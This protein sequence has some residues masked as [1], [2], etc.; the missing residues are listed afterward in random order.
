MSDLKYREKIES[1]LFY[2]GISK[3]AYERVK[4]PV[5]ESN[6]RAFKHWSALA[7]FFWCYCLLMSLRAEDYT[8]CRPAYIVSLAVCIVTY[9]CY[10]LVMPR[11]PQALPV[12]VCLLRLSLLF[13]GIGIAIC[14]NNRTLLL[15]AI[16]FMSPIFFIDDTVAA[17]IPDV[18]A[19][20]GYIVLGK[21][22]I[23]PAVYD[24]GLRN[25][26]LFSLFGILI[27]HFIDRE[28]FERFVFEDSAKKLAEIQTR[29]A[30]YDQMTG[31]L[32]RRAYEEKIEELTKEMPPELCV[33]MADLNGLKKANDT[34]GHEAGDELII[35]ASECLSRAFGAYGT[36]YRIG[37]DEFCVIVNKG[38][39]ETTRCLDH[40]RE[41][42]AKWKGRYIDGIS[43]SCGAESN[44]NSTDIETIFK[45]ADRKMYEEKDN[46]YKTTGLDRRKI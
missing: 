46:Y 35:G 30:Y 40:L 28:R 9:L 38:M 14:Q 43:I 29:Y 17:L 16:A 7:C 20:I 19:L 10:Q 23:T 11:F 42:S 45:E 34:L 25:F 24:W 22:V 26:I 3:E 21:N 15:F 39:P 44:R 2:G 13:G 5:T 37:G 31:L 18:L 27:G 12:F 32:N 1:V 4:Q 41:I 33:V 36:V 6:Q 8:L